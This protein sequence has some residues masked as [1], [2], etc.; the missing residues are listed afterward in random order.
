[1]AF[2][3]INLVINSLAHEKELVSKGLTSAEMVKELNSSLTQEEYKT[4][5]RKP[6]SG[7]GCPDWSSSR[8]TN[9]KAPIP[10]LPKSDKVIKK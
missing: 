9:P 4:I 6:L 1:M 10:I 8:Y 5:A 7:V 3:N 2:K